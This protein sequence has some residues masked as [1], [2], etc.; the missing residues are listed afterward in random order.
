LTRNRRAIPL[1][2][3]NATIDSRNQMLR[4]ACGNMSVAATIPETENVKL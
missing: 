3:K 1:R 4:D 2:K